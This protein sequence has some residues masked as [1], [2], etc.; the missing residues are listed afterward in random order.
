MKNKSTKNSD[1]ELQQGGQKKVK[2]NPLIVARTQGS[3]PS[4]TWFA[5]VVRKAENILS[6]RELFL[7]ITSKASIKIASGEA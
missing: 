5:P 6:G 3:Y 2:A 4:G 7:E 1:R